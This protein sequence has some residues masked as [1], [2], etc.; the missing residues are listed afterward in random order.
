MLRR[1]LFSMILS[2]PIGCGDS[3]GAGGAGGIGGGAGGASGRSESWA[4]QT[5]IQTPDGR[6]AFIQ[7]VDSPGTAPLDVS[8]AREVPGNGR[9]YLLNGVAYIGDPEALTVVRTRPGEVALEDDSERLSF[10]ATGIAFLPSFA[11]Y[12]SDDEAF[13]LDAAGGTGYGW[14]LSEMTLG[15]R[16]DLTSVRKEGF[17]PTIETAVVR[18]GK[19]YFVVQQTDALGLQAFEGLQTGVIDLESGTVTD[20]SEDLRCVRTRSRMNLAEDGTIYLLSDNYGATDALGPDAPPTCMLRILPGQDEL[21]QDWQIDM[22][23][24]LGGRQASSFIYVGNGLGYASVIYD[25]EVTISLAEDPVGYF[26]QPASRWWLIDLNMETGTEVA[27]LPFHSLAGGNGAI[28]DGR[29]FLFT[30]T[31]RFEGTSQVWE[32]DLSDPA[33]EPTMVYETDGAIPVLGRVND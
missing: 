7:L 9:L 21:D 19:I 24:L 1:I 6:T 17:E 30:P 18:D 11:V 4:V 16:V 33:G 26:S 8:L 10:A 2:L 29:V 20:V 15:R 5:V 22:P 23:E 28:S 25:E 32:P 12:A 31:N 14:S 27:G 3:S 13:L